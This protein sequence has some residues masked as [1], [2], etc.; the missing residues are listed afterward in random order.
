MLVCDSNSDHLFELRLTLN[1]RRVP[2]ESKLKLSS[3]ERQLF[4]L[5]DKEYPERPK[6]DEDITLAFHDPEILDDYGQTLNKQHPFYVDSVVNEAY[7]FH[8]FASF[9][10]IDLIK[11]HIEPENRNYLLDGTFKIVPR[12]LNQL[13]IISIEFKNDVCIYLTVLKLIFIIP[14]VLESH[15]SMLFNPSIIDFRFFEFFEFL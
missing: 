11:E 15:F 7:S 4:R 9:A 12:G 1:F 14:C 13:L 6:T 3:I 10:T 5:R 8:I 2:G